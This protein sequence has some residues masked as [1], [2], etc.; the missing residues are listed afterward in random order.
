MKVALHEHG[1]IGFH[2]YWLRKQVGNLKA[3]VLQLI[4]EECFGKKLD[5]VAIASQYEEGQIDDLSTGLIHD[6]FGYLCREGERL[7]EEYSV[8]SDGRGLLVVKKHGQKV[9]LLNAQSV[10]VRSNG[11]RIDTIIVGDNRTPVGRPI[12]YILDYSGERGFINI[13]E[14]IAAPDLYS[15]GDDIERF[16]EKYDAFEWNAQMIIFPWMTRMPFVGKAIKSA[17]RDNNNQVLEKAQ[18]LDKPVVAVGDSHR[19]E[20]IGV[21]NIYLSKPFGNLVDCEIDKLCSEAVLSHLKEAIRQRE[22]T[23]NYGLQSFFGLINWR[24]IYVGGVKVYLGEDALPEGQRQKGDVRLGYK[25]LFL[26]G[27]RNQ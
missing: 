8:D 2:D 27:F 11:R 21:A 4:A 26:K 18:K 17:C 16:F 6:R 12:D 19:I 14:H 24:L 20:D 7:P 15:L 3:N 9:T 23:N 1:L 22:F 13:A 25:N 10:R 5:L